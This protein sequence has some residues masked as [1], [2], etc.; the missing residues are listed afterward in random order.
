[1]NRH[2][3]A[4]ALPRAGDTPARRPT[5]LAAALVLAAGLWIAAAP[6]HADNVQASASQNLSGTA[7][8][9]NGG[10]SASAQ[11]LPGASALATRDVLTVWTDGTTGSTATTAFSA[12]A[13]AGSQ[14]V[15]W[16]LAADRALTQA[17]ADAIDL[18]FN[19]TLTGR[20]LVDPIS[21][22]TASMGY[23]VALYSTGFENTSA[24]SSSVFGPTGYLHLGA[25]WI[26]D[27]TQ[28]FTLMHRSDADGLLTTYLSSGAA[29]QARAYGTLSVD[30]VTLAAG[31]L[32][33]GGLGVRLSETGEIWVVSSPVP[34]PAT[35]LQLIAGLGAAGWLRRRHAVARDPKTQG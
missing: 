18:A 14:Y 27:V 8:D 26:G 1:M 24:N 13:A 16:D 3:L 7:Q 34:E 23:S 12:I 22:S 15:L 21:L 30:S 5:A 20:V 31:A 9:V 6:A 29:F 32:P 11:W 35:W 2:P 19:F 4:P 10:A 33:V 28:S 17:E 25:Q